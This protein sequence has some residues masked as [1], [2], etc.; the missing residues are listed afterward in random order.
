MTTEFDEFI[1]D[2]NN[3]LEEGALKEQLHNQ[4]DIYSEEEMDESIVEF[5]GKYL[6]R[7]IAY[8]VHK[9]K[10][11]RWRARFF[12]KIILDNFTRIEL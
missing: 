6:P 7:L 1:E 5:L 8:T 12:L 2:L 3:A 10:L 11:I 4:L 9:D